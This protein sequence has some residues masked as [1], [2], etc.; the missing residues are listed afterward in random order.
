MP[1]S[2]L[3][4]LPCIRRVATQQEH[5]LSD[6]VAGLSRWQHNGGISSRRHSTLYVTFANPTCSLA[7]FFIVSR[8]TSRVEASRLWHANCHTSGRQQSR[9]E[10]RCGDLP[11]GLSILFSHCHCDDLGRKKNVDRSCCFGREQSH[12]LCDWV[13]HV[14]VWLYPRECVLHLHKRIQSAGMAKAAEQSIRI[15]D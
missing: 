12:R 10:A 2:T 11:V 6:H 13:A 14:T 3:R 7:N 8:T 4:I 15:D 5:E 1:S 9:S